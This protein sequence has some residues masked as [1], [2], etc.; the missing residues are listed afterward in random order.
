LH[1]EI[2]CEKRENKEEIELGFYPEHF[3]GCRSLNW[4][5]AASGICLS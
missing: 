2:N 1:F 5:V 3:A 4:S